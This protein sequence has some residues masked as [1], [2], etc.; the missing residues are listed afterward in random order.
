MTELPS[1]PGTLV[2]LIL[3]W[4]LGLAVLTG[5]L[6]RST[7]WNHPII[8]GHSYFVGL[9]FTTLII[10]A[11]DKLGLPLHFWGIAATLAVLAATIHYSTRRQDRAAEAPTATTQGEA[12]QRI[13]ICLLLALIAYRYCG[14]AQ[15]IWLRP[16][17]PWDA[18]MNW[19]PKAVV[20]FNLHELAAY[21]S[22]REWLD[23]P[24]D[25]QSY[26]TGALNAWKYPET[27]PLIQLW[28]MLGAGASD[29]NYSNLPWL[30]A[31]LAFALALYGHLRSSGSSALVAVIAC[32][33]LLSIPYLTVHAALAGYADLWL[34]LAFGAGA[35]ALHEWQVARNWSW[36][37]LTFLFAFAC[38][39]LKLPGII[40]GG[41]IL[42]VFF[43]SAINPSRKT[44]VIAASTLL[45]V[46]AFVALAGLDL[47]IPALGR[48]KIST[49]S[50][51]VPH[52]GA[53]E[54]HYRPVHAALASSLFSLSNWNI[55]WY[56]FITLLLLKTAGLEILNRPS[57]E[58]QCIALVFL[59]FGFVFYFTHISQYVQD[60]TTVN[61]A[62]L[63]IIPASVFYACRSLSQPAKRQMKADYSTIAV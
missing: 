30:L 58:L 49:T 39:Q 29:Q 63:Y 50:I 27:V 12:W 10:R 20:W 44:V 35:M 4:L 17:Y 34:A 60:F 51:V 1:I 59:F 7:G 21:V 22:P 23:N 52:L 28:G 53:Y 33:I 57:V 48:L 8:V 9:F 62:I 43:V 41:I 56:L 19:A 2:A 14:L 61:R 42:A 47:E 38:T 5:V 55:F 6:R 18:W 13:A 37:L 46:S 32:Y 45:A 15:E 24:G 31:P 3:P 36:G 16:L 54:L 40:L 11:W 26:T 25:V